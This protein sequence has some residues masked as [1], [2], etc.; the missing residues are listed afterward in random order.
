MEYLWACPSVIWG[1]GDVRSYKVLREYCLVEVCYA[2]LSAGATQWHGSHAGPGTALVM[3]L[4]KGPCGV[5]RTKKPEP[6]RLNPAP[7]PRAASNILA[8]TSA[9]LDDM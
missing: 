3:K 4:V 8:F 2:R 6:Q 1:G 9:G 5:H 7:K